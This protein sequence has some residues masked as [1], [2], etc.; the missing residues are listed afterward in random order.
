MSTGNKQ[1]YI[2]IGPPKTATT[3]FQKYFNKNDVGGINYQGIIQPRSSNDATFCKRLHNA[4]FGHITKNHN[5]RPDLSDDEIVFCSE[6]MFLVES[7]GIAWQYK[8]KALFELTESFSPKIIIVLR[9]PKDAIRSYYQELYHRLDTDKIASINDF[10]KSNYCKIYDYDYLVK[11]LYLIGFKK[12]I[13]LDF[14]YLVNGRYRISD[15]FD[16]NNH[17]IVNLNK[18]NPSKASGEKYYSNNSDKKT[19]LDV[20]IQKDVINRFQKNYMSI[21]N[22]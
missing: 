7:H 17:D 22:R 1:L 9:D 11:C 16:C 18:E 21:L 15:I 8:I 13:M 2:H 10:A 20:E 4:I 3:S 5:I 12:V 6:E 19:S 14:N